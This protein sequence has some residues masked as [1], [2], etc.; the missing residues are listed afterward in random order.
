MKTSARQ[1]TVSMI[2]A[3]TFIFLTM[4]LFSA[5]AKRSNYIVSIAN[6]SV[7][8]PTRTIGSK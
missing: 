7:K 6:G 5:C 8:V 3:S 4:V 2:Q 1:N